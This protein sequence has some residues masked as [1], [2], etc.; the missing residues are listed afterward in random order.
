MSNRN[1]LSMLA[2]L[3]PLMASAQDKCTAQYEA[4]QARIIRELP[5]SARQKA[6]EML[7]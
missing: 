7:K 3:L 6:T 2:A 4:E 1:T 5:G